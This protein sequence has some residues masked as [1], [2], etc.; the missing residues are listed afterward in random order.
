MQQKRPFRSNTEKWYNILTKW[1]FQDMVWKYEFNKKT[2]LE[3]QDPLCMR[4]CIADCSLFCHGG[5]E[6]GFAGHSAVLCISQH[7]A[8]VTMMEK[9]H[10][11]CWTSCTGAAAVGTEL[12]ITTVPVKPPGDWYRNGNECGRNVTNPSAE[13]CIVHVFSLVN[14]QNLSNCN[15]TQQTI[16]SKFN[17]LK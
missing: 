9:T 13:V 16:N 8:R 11:C 4:G 10:L 17:C 12:W 5:S 14:K 1:G 3:W 15:F 7:A 6:C 2:Y